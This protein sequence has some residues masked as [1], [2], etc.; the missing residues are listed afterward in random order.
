[1]ALRI[2][3]R[4]ARQWSTAQGGDCRTGESSP[5]L[6]RQQHDR[7]DEHAD[8]QSASMQSVLRAIGTALNLTSADSAAPSRNCVL[9]R[10]PVSSFG[11]DM[12]VITSICV[13]TVSIK[14]IPRFFCER[15]PDPLPLTVLTEPPGLFDF[16]EVYQYFAGTTTS[17]PRTP[18]PMPT[19]MRTVA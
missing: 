7:T 18:G 8:H 4:P 12:R 16:I 10:P 11:H 13:S 3:G 5:G 19:L 2:D 9:L 17:P 15:I 14:C 1:M 6:K